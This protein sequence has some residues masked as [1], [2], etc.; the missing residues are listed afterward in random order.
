MA[1]LA[2]FT[3]VE[4]KEINDYQKSDKFHP[5]TCLCSNTKLVA[6]QDG[7]VCP[8]CGYVQKWVYNWIPDGAWRN[9]KNG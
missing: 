9:K 7:L 1:L 4:V 6:E 8:K 3:K 5:F 2:P